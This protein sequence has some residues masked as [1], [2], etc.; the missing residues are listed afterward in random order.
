MLGARCM[1]ST[2]RP[3]PLLTFVRLRR[4]LA[5]TPRN[6]EQI[7]LKQDNIRDVGKTGAAEAIKPSVALS[8]TKWMQHSVDSG[9]G[10]SDVEDEEENLRK[11][12]PHYTKIAGWDRS[13]QELKVLGKLLSSK[14]ARETSDV[15]VFQRYFTSITITVVSRCWRA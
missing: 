1:I 10:D 7:W 6:D 11:K 12:M 5:K 13:N 15:Q 3:K 9:G 14:R 8:E 4:T 2:I